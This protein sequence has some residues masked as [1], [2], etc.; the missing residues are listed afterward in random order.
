MTPFKPTS[1]GASSN[2]LEPTGSSTD[3][4]PTNSV[5]NT[6]SESES[7]QQSTQPDGLITPQFKK[8]REIMLKH[9]VK[10]PF[11]AEFEL[12]ELIYETW[13]VGFNERTKLQQRWM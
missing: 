2:G 12:I 13:N 3:Q 5:A 11:M 9:E 8:M 7:N 10:L 6:S 4:T 1:T